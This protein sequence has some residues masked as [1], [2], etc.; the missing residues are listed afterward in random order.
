MNYELLAELQKAQENFKGTSFA[1]L[2]EKAFKLFEGNDLQEAQ[3]TLRRL[4]TPEELL[5]KLIEKLKG[6][7]VYKTL[8]R[9]NEG[10]VSDTTEYLKGLYSLSTHVLIECQQHP[11]YKILL[12]ILYKKIGEMIYKI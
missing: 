12:P 2:V 1:S 11:E 8:K 10:T 9:I 6:K 3:E 4:P 7:S 5:K